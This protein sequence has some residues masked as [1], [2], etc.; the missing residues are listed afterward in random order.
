VEYSIR[1]G[2][3]RKGR[4]GIGDIT[5]DDLQAGVVS[6]LLKI[7]APPDAKIVENPDVAAFS[8]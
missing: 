6:M 8:Q 1:A 5:L 7:L 4:R 2:T 3:G